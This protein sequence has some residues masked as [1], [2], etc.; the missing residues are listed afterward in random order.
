M[1]AGNSVLGF[2]PCFLASSISSRAVAY[3]SENGIK[4]SSLILANLSAISACAFSSASA[5]ASSVRTSSNGLMIGRGQLGLAGEEVGGQFGA[6]LEFRLAVLVRGPQLRLGQLVLDA[7]RQCIAVDREDL[8]LDL[9]RDLEAGR[10]A[11]RVGQNVLVLV[12]TSAWISSGGRL[13]HLGEEFLDGN[14]DQL[15]RDA[16]VLVA[17]G[18]EDVVGSD[19][20][21]P[22]SRRTL[23]RRTWLAMSARSCSPLTRLLRRLEQDLEQFAGHLVVGDPLE[24]FPAHL[25]PGRETQPVG[26]VLEDQG[27]DQVAVLGRRRTGC[28]R[29]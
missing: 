19:Q 9:A 7:P 4:T 25:G 29:R 2:V 14:L 22:S 17:I 18:P 15:G 27:V 8:D 21:A 20:R 5:T 1:G 24:E 16:L 13:G 28:G 23:A 10:L 26:L 12:R 3:S 11:G 6:F